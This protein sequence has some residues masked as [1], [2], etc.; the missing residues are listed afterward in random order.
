MYSLLILLL[1]HLTE[2]LTYSHQKPLENKLWSEKC[3]KNSVVLNDCNWCWCDSRQRYQCK[4]RVCN[5]IDMF[6]HYNDAIRDID[7]GMEGRGAWRS[8]ATS[9]SPG[10]H[11]QRGKVLCVCD[12]DGDWPNPVCK[13]L[14]L[15]LYE[16]NLTG[17][18]NL[19]NWEPCTPTKLYLV[20]CNVCFCPYTG[21][22]DPKLCTK[23]ECDDSLY[24]TLDVK[25]GP[26][27]I[28]DTNVTD[29][30]LEVYAPCN[31]GIKYKLG[32]MKCICIGNNKLVCDNCVNEKSRDIT[33]TDQQSIARNNY[34]SYCNDKKI[35]EIFKINCN[36]CHCD[37]KLNLLCT[38]KKCIEPRNVKLKSKFKIGAGVKLRN[39]VAPP[40][41][42]SCL[43]N[44]QYKKDCNTC[45]CIKLRRG[46]KV[47]DCTVENC[48]QRSPMEIQKQ[49]CVES[50]YY[51]VD[52]KLCY[53]YIADN[54]KHQVCQMDD[55][56]VQNLVLNEQTK[57][58]KLKSVD[59][60][61][62]YC[63]PLHVYRNN[64]NTCRC[65]SDGKTY[66][67]TSKVC[68]ERSI[69]NIPVD[70]VPVQMSYNEAC[71]AGLSYKLDCNVCYCLS[72]GNAVC[73]TNDCANED[74]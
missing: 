23:R 36:Y 14:F 33:F 70:I 24:P 15:V 66:M 9:C 59:T 5:E 54:V 31:T 71:P 49:D 25:E 73:T 61:D 16:V 22:L 19:T 29:N 21:F 10:V 18:T 50:S 3:K 44:T 58:T 46:N 57:K 37:R 2:V 41:D 6:G 40:D 69:D 39:A 67:C 17:K 43:S 42:Q 63:E 53:C 72:N 68:V 20:G 13:A 52:C 51:K 34:N 28:S 48:G 1:F 62:G 4:A 74:V 60:Q 64:C 65:L 26:P 32:C 8:K 35:G 12:E 47:V 38:A 30:N 56:C 7:V 11:Y 55:N 27:L 45:K